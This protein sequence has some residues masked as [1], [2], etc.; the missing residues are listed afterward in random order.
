M[1]IGG[2]GQ[3]VNGQINLLGSTS[4]STQLGVTTTGSSLNLGVAPN[5]WTLDT[6]GF[7][8]AKS[9]TSS[10]PGIEVEN[11]TNDSSDVAILFLKDRA[12]ANTLTN[13]LFGGL[14]FWGWANGGFSETALIQVFQAASSGAFIPS[15]IQFANSTAAGQFANIWLMRS[16]G[17]F[18]SPVGLIAGNNGGVSGTLSLFGSTSSGSTLSVGATGILTVASANGGIAVAPSGVNSGFVQL[19]GSTSGGTLLIGSATGGHLTYFG[20]GTAPSLTAGCNGAGSSVSANAT[21]ISGTATGQ[22]AAATTCTLTFGTTL[23]AAPN[24]SVNG[25]SSPLTGAVTIS[26]SAI[27]VNFASTANYKWTW[28][29]DGV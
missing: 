1:N 19:N 25:L 17:S 6:T 5:I 26:T 22:T 21:D 23:A 11:D 27:V 13:D 24:C 20:S 4:G 9:S 15:D 8:F 7:W 14:Q 28:K 12:S 3:A 10:R 2:P 18:L 29:C 16:D